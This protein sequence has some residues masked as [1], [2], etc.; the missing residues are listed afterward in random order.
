MKHVLRLTLVMA[1]FA[2][3]ASTATAQSGVTIFGS[4]DNGLTYVSNIGGQSRISMQDGINKSNSL[5]FSGSEDLGDGKYAM[6]RLENG[7][8]LNNGTMGQ[9]GLMFGKQ[10]WIAVGDRALGDLTIGR[11]YDFAY[12]L[13]RYYPCANCGIIG[14]ENADLDRVSGERVNNAVQFVSREIAG[15]TFGAQYAFGQNSGTLST[16]L[17]R[18]ISA[19]VRYANGPFS[20][21]FAYS[22]LNQVPV[23]AGLTGAPTVLGVHVTPATVLIADSQRI[24]GGGLRYEFARYSVSMLYT[25]TRLSLNGQSE[26][27]QVLHIGGDFRASPQ[28]LLSAKVSFDELGDSHWYS[29][30]TG[31]TYFLSKRTDI[32]LD[33]VAQRATGAGTKASIA[34]TGVSSVDHQ[35]VAHAGIRHFF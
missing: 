34:M 7:F 28:L 19:N 21:G 8:N 32:Y 15:L 27:D 35:F 11:Q 6:F 12:Q 2:T 24:L 16:N 20:A 30:T 22:D 9:G 14:V 31:T 13:F 5:G 18:E 26:T 29:V 10:A 17:G 1:W 3:A 23:F 4:V 25:N 33:L